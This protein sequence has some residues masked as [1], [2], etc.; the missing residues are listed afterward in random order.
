MK[1]KIHTPKAPAATDFY[2]QAIES[3]GFIFV[4]GQLHMSPEGKLIEGT[5]RE[6][7]EQIMKNIQAI[8][9]AAGADFVDVVKTTVYV[10]NMED[11]K[12]INKLYPNYFPNPKPAREAVCVS[13]L[14]LGASIEISVIAEK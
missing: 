14:P 1:I 11:L 12:E 5:I 4:A 6:K 13:Q 2:S 10:T 7:L 9:H 3:N 8:L